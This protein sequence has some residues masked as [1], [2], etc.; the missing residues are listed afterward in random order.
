MLE[1]NKKEVLKLSLK[2][3]NIYRKKLIMDKYMKIK[4]KANFVIILMTV[5]LILR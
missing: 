4:N 5:I 2:M 3:G 1:M